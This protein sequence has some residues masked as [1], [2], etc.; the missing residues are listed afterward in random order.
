V[1]HGL[2]R[3][4]RLNC[5][6]SQLGWLWCIAMASPSQLNSQPSYLWVLVWLRPLRMVTPPS[7]ELPR[8]LKLEHHITTH[9]IAVKQL[10]VSC[11]RDIPA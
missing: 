3:R 5:P 1:G 2:T 8:P 4:P 7:L 9:L 10:R 11:A 6:P